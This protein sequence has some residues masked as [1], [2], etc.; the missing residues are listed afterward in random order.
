MNVADNE[1]AEHVALAKQISE[2]L[3]AR[4]PTP[5]DGLVVLA[6]VVGFTFASSH[7][8]RLDI[9]EVWQRFRRLAEAWERSFKHP[10][11]NKT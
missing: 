1:G 11:R 5:A 8:P 3:R 2:L 6:M 9:E 10:T 4:V 7:G